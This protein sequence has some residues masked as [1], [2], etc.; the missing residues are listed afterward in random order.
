MKRNS[1]LFILFVILGSLL[2]IGGLILMIVN[3][4]KPFAINNL[5]P[6][7]FLLAGFLL[8]II[9][10][11]VIEMSFRIRWMHRIEHKLDEL[12]EQGKD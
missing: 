7:V 6:V 4:S 3:L 8:V 2:C 5:K 9:G 11:I 12:R 1:V 10:A